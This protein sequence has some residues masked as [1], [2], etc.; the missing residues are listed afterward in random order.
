MKWYFLVFIIESQSFEMNYAKMNDF[1]IVS[2]WKLFP[3][4]LVHIKTEWCSFFFILMEF[5]GI[6]W[7]C[8]AIF[9]WTYSYGKSCFKSMPNKTRIQFENILWKYRDVSLENSKIPTK[10]WILCCERSEKSLNTAENKNGQWSFTSHLLVWLTVLAVGVQHANDWLYPY[11]LSYFI[12][13][14]SLSCEKRCRNVVI[15]YESSGFFL[16]SAHVPFY[17]LH[18]MWM[19]QMVSG[20]WK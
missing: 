16:S 3:K 12:I 5:V 8:L 15:T 19:I 20:H 1:I 2:I 17:Y 13:S 9:Y 7:N 4:K 11:K 18:G 6:Y 14:Q 10:M